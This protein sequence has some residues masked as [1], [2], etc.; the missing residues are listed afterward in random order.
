MLITTMFIGQSLAATPSLPTTMEAIPNHDGA[1]K[2]QSDKTSHEVSNL[3]HAFAMTNRLGSLKAEPVMRGAKEVQLFKELAPSVVLLEV[4]DKDGKGIGVG[5]GTIVDL[6]GRILT[7]WHVI[8]GGVYVNAYLKPPLGEAPSK[9]FS[10][11]VLKK[12]KKKDLALMEFYDKP[13]GVHPARLANTDVIEIGQDVHAIGHPKG[14]FWTFTSGTV[15]NYIKASNPVSTHQ[16]TVIMTAAA[17]NS[18]N[19]GGPL[20]NDEG[21]VIGVNTYVLRDSQA[22]NYAVSAEEVRTFL[23][24]KDEEETPKPVLLASGDGVNS[25]DSN[26]DGKADFWFIDADG[27]GYHEWMEVDEDFDGKVDRRYLD[28]D[29][30]SIPEAIGYDTNE[31]GKIDSW[32]IDMD[33]DG[34]VESHAFDDNEDGEIDRVE[35]V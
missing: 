31:N 25:F 22:M 7:N 30:D 18:G 19:S 6:K 10:V 28:K 16:A 15:S 23:A 13:A 5:S 26:A 8:E 34:N 12:D 3:T 32:A 14:E 29:D 11:K 4:L 33:E 1:T 17:L 21:V 20:L 27:D 2:I 35:R 9:S 24:R